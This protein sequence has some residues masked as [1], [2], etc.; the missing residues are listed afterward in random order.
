MIA[1]EIHYCDMYEQYQTV[2][3]S[4][5]SMFEGGSMILVWELKNSQDCEIKLAMKDSIF[6]VLTSLLK[7]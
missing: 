4:L 3:K 5:F 1:Q 2:I 7:V 6:C